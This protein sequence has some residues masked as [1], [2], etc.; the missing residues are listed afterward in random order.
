MGRGNR[1]IDLPECQG[2][3]MVQYLGNTYTNRLFRKANPDEDSRYVSKSEMAFTP[4]KP[5]S[6]L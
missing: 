5:R 2:S 6:A 3:V 4:R 1:M